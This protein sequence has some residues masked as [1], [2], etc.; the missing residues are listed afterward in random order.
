MYIFLFALFNF[1]VFFLYSP[2][3]SAFFA[4]CI[5]YSAI[6]LDNSAQLIDFLSFCFYTLK[7]QIV[8]S[9]IQEDTMSK[10]YQKIS[11][12]LTQLQEKYNVQIC[13]KD[14]CGFVPINKELDEA[15]Q[16]F[17][18][19][20]NPY[21]M[22]MK[23]D[24]SHWHVCLSMIRGIYAKC[25]QKKETFFGVCHGGL[26]EYV[27]PIFNEDNLL[28]SV[29]AGF[30]PI[31]EKR[32]LHRIAHTCGQKPPLDEDTALSLYRSSIQTPTISPEDLIPGLE[33]LAEYLAQTYQLIQQTHTASANSGRFYASSE[34]TILTHS[35]E[36]IRQN[37]AGKIT[38]A[39]VANFCHCSE[40][41]ISRIF[42]RRTGVNINVY[43][44]KIRV[45]QAKNYLMLSQNS[46]AEIACGVGFSDPNYFSRV[47][48]QIIGIPPTEYRRR[49]SSSGNH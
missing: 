48:T 24:R 14:F 32:A 4:D 8:P 29:N 35:L 28:G 22:Y 16:P 10:S 41:Y 34:D 36:Y 38:V 25:E 30:F 15:L 44:N 37:A 39:D 49:F 7:Y 5:E 20:T 46:I 26:G 47:F 13:I 31:S 21:C 11:N 6:F 17:L 40:S 27:I 19:H 1:P 2:M 23:S 18:A 9:E 43:V 45:E 33:M 42:K 3:I 12:Y